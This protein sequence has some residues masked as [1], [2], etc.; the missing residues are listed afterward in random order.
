M[1][2]TVRRGKE[3][4]SGT[5]HLKTYFIRSVFKVIGAAA[6][7]GMGE[8]AWAAEVAVSGGDERPEVELAQ[9]DTGVS[10]LQFS[11][12]ETKEFDIPPGPLAEALNRFQQDT[13]IA[14]EVEPALV[15]DRRTLGLQGKFS[16]EQALR[17]LLT[18]TGLVHRETPSGTVRLEAQDAEESPMLMMPLIEVRSTFD[19]LNERQ[20][21]AAAKIIIGPEEIAKFGETSMGEVI[22]RMPSVSFGGPPGENND[23]RLRGL[24]KDYTQILIDGRPMTG[25]D[26][27]IDQ[28]PASQVERIE[29]IRT[30]TADMDAQGIAGAVNIVLKKIPVERTF[31]WKLG[32]GTMPE[33]PGS[34]KMGNAALSF[35]ENRGGFG[36]LISGSIQNRYGIRTK[37]RKDYSGAD[38][39]TLV[40][41]EKDFEVREHFEYSLTSRLNWTPSVANTIRFDPKFLFSYEDKDRERLKRADL[42]DEEFMNAEKTRR[43]FGADLE[44][45]HRPG[46]NTRYTFGAEVQF[47]DEDKNQEDFRGRRTDPALA[48]AAGSEGQVYERSLGLRL[49]GLWVVGEKHSVES[50]LEWIPSEW[51]QVNRTWRRVDESDRV[52]TR[53]EVEEQKMAAF[54]QDEYLYSP[55][56]VLTPGLR[57]EYV[58]GQSEYA[59][60]RR[61]L[62]DDLHLGPSLHWLHNLTETTNLRASVTRTIRRPKY[63]DLVPSA[64]IKR[65]T[66][67]DPDK[68]G[69]PDLKPE[70]AMGFES[71]IERYF[72]EKR[73]V[74]SL[75]FFYRDLTDL[76]EKETQFNASNGRWEQRPVNVDEGK[77]WGMEFDGSRRL[78]N[79]GL[80]GL[81]LRGNYSWLDSSTRDRFTGDKRRINEQPN[82]I[83]NLGVD[84]E[85][86]PWRTSV[87]GNYN[88]VGRLEKH[89]IVGANRRVQKQDPS[90]YLDVYVVQRLTDHIRLRLSGVNL[91]EIEKNRPRYTYDSAGNRVFFE[92]EDET[93][94]RAFFVTLEGKI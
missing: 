47:K 91:L 53:A 15:R 24:Q 60:E 22:R 18:G 88:R 81:T 13:G 11:F 27:P 57:V 9:R 45:Q 89:D 32:A 66:E 94:A 39:N 68:V 54:I 59:G 36:Y 76:V 12:R 26:F 52:R 28:I 6:L 19:E 34:G 75:N 44:W 30:P 92:Q 16:V 38:L 93:S 72:A 31:S 25:R 63:E 35:G 87:G 8:P 5:K 29:I 51:N 50:G 49:S 73:G 80:R 2:A 7:I 90:H 4:Y 21:L 78:D 48:F 79:W 65:G 40:N 64:D 43:Y 17:R 33:A 84:Y 58:R 3:C 42:S 86:K 71:S 41:R 10:Q 67:D 1:G 20:N 61:D 69:N 62:N 82:Y 55:R 85:Y 23:A 56:T 70:K 77:L 37:D 74:V 46:P 83:L 14:L